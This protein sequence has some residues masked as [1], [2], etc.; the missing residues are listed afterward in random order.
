MQK[1][2]ELYEL[3]KDKNRIKDLVTKIKSVL[4]AARRKHK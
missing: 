3:V 2:D 1:V 4:S